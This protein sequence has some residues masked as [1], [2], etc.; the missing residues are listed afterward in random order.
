MIVLPFMLIDRI[1]FLA[2]GFGRLEFIIP[3]LVVWRT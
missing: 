2:S 3:F 1:K